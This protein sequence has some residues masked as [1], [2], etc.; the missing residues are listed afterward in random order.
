MF[1]ILPMPISLE[2]FLLRC[3]PTPKSDVLYEPP[4]RQF[5]VFGSQFHPMILKC[6]ALT[7]I[8]KRNNTLQGHWMEW[9]KEK[10]MTNGQSLCDYFIIFTLV[11]N[12]VNMFVLN[13][14]PVWI[15]TDSNKY[16]GW[17]MKK[18]HFLSLV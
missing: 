16:A 1:S 18:E 11:V 6:F 15:L 3:L 13:A 2:Q 17:I 10:K 5:V 8:I 4:L 7:H 9:P 12:V 14:Y